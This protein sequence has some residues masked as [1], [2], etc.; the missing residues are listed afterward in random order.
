MH[1][2]PVRQQWPKLIHALLGSCSRQAEF[3]SLDDLMRA[4]LDFNAADL[5]ILV[6][7]PDYLVQVR[8]SME[9]DV[10]NVVAYQ[11]P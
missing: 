4:A 11:V 6:D 1:K 10:A 7:P 5:S 9:G 8:L 3:G 2:K